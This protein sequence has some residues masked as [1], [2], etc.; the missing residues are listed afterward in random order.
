MTPDLWQLIRQLEREILE[1]I[2]QS[3]FDRLHAP[4]LLHDLCF[5]AGV[6]GVYTLVDIKYAFEAMKLLKALEKY[7][8]TMQQ[9]EQAPITEKEKER[10][11]GT[12]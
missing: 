12:L 4:F 6:K 5:M 8:E 7:Q 11:T 1:E 9:I 2:G 10:W 3:G